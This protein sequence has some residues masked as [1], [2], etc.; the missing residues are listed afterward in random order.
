MGLV[1]WFVAAGDADRSQ[2][3]LLVVSYHFPPSRAAGALR[4]QKL[5]R[6]A[7]EHGWGLDVIAAAPPPGVALEARAFADL[8]PGTRVYGIQESAAPWEPLEKAA[9]KMLRGLRPRPPRSAAATPGSA[10]AAAPGAALAAESFTRSELPAVPRSLKDL[11]RAYVA[12]TQN[13]REAIWARR[14]AA[15]GASLIVPG[16]H[17]AIVSCGPPH[18]AHEAGRLLAERTGLPLVM[19]LR[20]PWSGVER[21]HESFASPVWYAVAERRERRCVR[22]AALVVMNTEPARDA[23]LSRYPALAGRVIAVMNGC[24]DE[25]LPVSPAGGPFRVM[26]TGSVYL[27]RDPRLL[28]RAAANVV[29]EFGLTPD[30]FMVDFVGHASSY[31]GVTI[32]SLA[33]SEGLEGQVRLHAHV[34]RERLME[35]LAEA[36]LLVSLPQDS[37]LAIPSKIFEYLRFP[38]WILAFAEPGSATQALLAGT[39]AD[40]VTHDDTAGA[41]AA[42]RRS[43]TKYR[44]GTRPLPI[45]AD[46]RFTRSHQAALLFGALNDVLAAP[47]VPVPDAAVSGPRQPVEA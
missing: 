1:P 5:S 39:G 23:M 6:F 47:P 44:D 42:I 46:P 33:A 17:R 21:L 41:T 2:R 37:N 25:P 19:D 11:H 38:A 16:W 9:W 24:D 7:G 18:M 28:L 35:M 12:A 4:W 27:D 32:E 36:A 8:P 45:G 13:T 22:R 10:P 43:Y 31:C 29:R 14:A 20:D 3:R 34:P 26:Y 30:D 40:V 15:L